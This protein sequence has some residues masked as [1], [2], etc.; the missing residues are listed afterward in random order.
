MLVCSDT[1]SGEC[2]PVGSVVRIVAMWP[3]R[4]MM[5]SIGSAGTAASVDFIRRAEELVP[6]LY[7][8]RTGQLLAFLHRRHAALVDIGG[9]IDQVNASL[10][11]LT[12][13][14]SHDG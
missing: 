14:N 6:R 11:L 12:G 2:R 3:N 1:P 5:G 8:S 13:F 9:K 4:L 10:C 7:L